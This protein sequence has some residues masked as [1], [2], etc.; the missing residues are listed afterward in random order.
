MVF[1]F[2]RLKYTGVIWA[3]LAMVALSYF[4]VYKGAEI[5]LLYWGTCKIRE[6]VSYMKSINPNSPDVWNESTTINITSPMEK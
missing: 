3:S 6:L 5:Y 1:H 2:Q 4:L